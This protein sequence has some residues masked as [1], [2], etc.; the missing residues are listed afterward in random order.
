MAWLVG[1]GILAGLLNA[2][3]GG[4]TFLSFPAL[5]FSGVPPLSANATNTLALFPAG[6][7][8]A[9]A[10]RRDFAESRGTL[11]PYAVAS[12]A[13]GAAG[14]AL[15]LHTPEET[16]RKLVPWLLL[17]A[18]V[19]FSAGPLLR[20]NPE[21]TGNGPGSW[22]LVLGSALQFA[23]S[24]YG[25][26]FGGGMGILMLAAWSLLAAGNIHAMNAMRSLLSALINGTAAIAF[27]IAGV[28][29]WRSCVVLAVA[30]TVSGYAGAA[31]VR[32]LDAVWVRRFVVA[33][34]WGMT[35]YFFARS[36]Y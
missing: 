6:G 13:G 29:A 35:I 31:G 11:I 5:V 2:V 26:Y 30:A 18:T 32:R 3:V 9:L 36:Y 25:G 20:T 28:I 19:V 12:M 21:K 10:Y 34:A 17:F 7:A 33:T 22:R 14:G 27:I 16:F 4:G 15:L 8:S 1:G 24:V 23:I